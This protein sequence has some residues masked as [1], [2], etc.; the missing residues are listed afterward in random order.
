M[1]L[2]ALRQHADITYLSFRRHLLSAHCQG[3]SF[4]QGHCNKAPPTRGSEQRVWQ[5]RVSRVVF[6]ADSRG[7]PSP[8]LLVPGGG[9]WSR[10]FWACACGVSVPAITGPPPW[11][12]CPCVSSSSNKD[13]SHI[14]RDPP[15]SRVT[16]S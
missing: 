3:L 5:L 10:R 4:S 12:S 6:S 15:N 8:P 2:C 14:G 9:Q 7:G 16:A 11:G 13:T 1:V